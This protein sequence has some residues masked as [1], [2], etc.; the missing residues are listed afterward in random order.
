MRQVI[1]GPDIFADGNADFRAVHVE[2][3]SSARRLEITVFVEHIVGWQKRLE[4]F[5]DW[6]AAF[7]QRCGVMKR[8]S[9]PGISVDVTNQQRRRADTAVK[10][11]QHLEG[12][13]N[14]PRLKHEVLGGVTGEREFRSQNNLSAF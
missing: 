3:L 1:F 13:R 7:E 6:F 10:F 11:S 14:K 4:R 8:F 5:P 12:L 2:G 9:F